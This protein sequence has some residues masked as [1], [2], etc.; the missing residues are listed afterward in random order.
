MSKLKLE[1]LP[2]K[3]L[4]WNV[5]EF[6]ISALILELQIKFEIRENIQN[7]KEK[8]IYGIYKVGLKFRI[9]SKIP[10]QYLQIDKTNTAT[11]EIGRNRS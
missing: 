11:L 3:V 10:P 5:K 7:W 2:V 6:D 9:W 1:T 8:F 4:R